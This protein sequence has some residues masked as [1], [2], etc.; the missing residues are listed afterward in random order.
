MVE[1]KH[2]DKQMLL[3]YVQQQPYENWPGGM[4]Q[5]IAQCEQCRARCVEYMRA[6]EL[7]EAWT[8]SRT[9]RGYPSITERVLQQV[10]Q[11]QTSLVRSS[12]RTGKR[13]SA[14]LT[15]VPVAVALLLL[16]CVVLLA[17]AYHY[18]PLPV[19]A[20]SNHIVPTATVVVPQITPQPYPSKTVPSGKK[21][22]HSMMLTPT[23]TN[24]S[25]P[26]ILR[27][28]SQEDKQELKKAIAQQKHRKMQV[29]RDHLYMFEKG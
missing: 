3:A 17:L 11:P 8:H 25:K 13:P 7:L 12:A 16:F 6:G 14:R 26:S 1:V 20:G 5:H 28:P 4:H 21:P 9:F 22:S 18:V 10:K 27:P 2:P 23:P 15:G 24:D 29:F 19:G